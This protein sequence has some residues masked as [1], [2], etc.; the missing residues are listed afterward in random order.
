MKN[1][2]LNPYDSIKELLSHSISQIFSSDETNFLSSSPV[3]DLQILRGNNIHDTCFQYAVKDHLGDKLL[4]LKIYDKI[5]DLVS[6]DGCHVVGSRISTILGSSR[7]LGLFEKRIRKAQYTGMTRLEV[8]IC[9][10]ALT[11]FRPDLPSLRI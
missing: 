2:Y 8:S 4:V 7:K 6:R 11:I 5:L 10:S 9:Y 3:S 1:K